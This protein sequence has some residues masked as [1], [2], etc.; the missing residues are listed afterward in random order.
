M[1]KKLVALSVLVVM[2]VTAFA[3]CGTTEQETSSVQQDTTV[4]QDI[5]DKVHVEQGFKTQQYVCTGFEYMGVS[6]EGDRLT[7]L[8][9]Y[10]LPTIL[11]DYEQN[12][13]TVDIPDTD[14]DGNDEIFTL[15]LAML[16]K[17]EDG[18]TYSGD[19]SEE[20]HKTYVYLGVNSACISLEYGDMVYK[21]N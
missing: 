11:V 10:N 9:G 3:G 13:F 2:I 1:L 4:Q 17:A 20:V 5:A 14:G 16:T 15:P 18:V 8:F 12:T 19:I 7:Q 6:F 21:F